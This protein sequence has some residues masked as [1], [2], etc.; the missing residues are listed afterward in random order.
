M[1]D[2]GIFVVGS[3]MFVI[4]AW[5]TVAFGLSRMRDLQARDMAAGATPKTARPGPWMT[6]VWASDEE[7][8]SAEQMGTSDS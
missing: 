8:T 3:V 6:E 4:T 7:R 5:A 1:T 2:V